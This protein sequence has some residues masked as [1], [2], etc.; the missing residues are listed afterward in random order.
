MF[1]TEQEYVVDSIRKLSTQTDQNYLVQCNDYISYKVYTNNGERIIDPDFELIKST[2]TTLIKEEKRYLVRSDGYAEL[3]MVG[4]V[5][6]AGYTLRQ[7]D[8]LLTKAY[9]KY[10]FGAYVTTY[11]LN[12]RAIVLGPK[13]AK[14]IPLENDNIS[15]IELLA[16]YGGMPEDGRASNIK[17]IRGDLKNPDVQII[18]LSSI[19]GLRKANLSV[20]PN[21]IVYIEPVKRIFSLTLQDI[22]PLLSLFLAV[23]SIVILLQAN[24]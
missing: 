12:K 3:P 7:C 16:L 8:S 21:D 23:L 22:Y 4:S 9:T 14:V 15:V 17:L 5:K 10:Y 24:R 13:Q 2:P 6:L 20:E 1:K 19:E 18:D 11:L